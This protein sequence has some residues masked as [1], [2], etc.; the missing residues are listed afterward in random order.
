MPV[1]GYMRQA[2][3]RNI[4]SI[5]RAVTGEPGRWMIERMIFGACVLALAAVG[6]AKAGASQDGIAALSR[7]DYAAAARIFRPLAERGNA[8][9]QTYLGYMYANGYGVPQNYIESARWYA[10]ASE[11]GDATAQ[12]MLGLMYD[13]GHGV[14]QDYVEAYKWLNLAVAGAT[15]RDRRDWVRIRDAV[16]SKLTLAQITRGQEL[17]IEWQATRVTRGQ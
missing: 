4:I 16:A 1:L 6:P 11:R 10:I 7:H 17:A 8:R 15:G 3:E 12:Y 13:K 14:P 9:A 5:A 2:A